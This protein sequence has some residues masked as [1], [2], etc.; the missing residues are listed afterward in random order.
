MKIRYG[1]VTNSSSSSFIVAFNNESEI[2]VPLEFHQRIME[3]ILNPQNS[4]TVEQALDYFEECCYYSI[5]YDV[6]DKMREDLG[7]GYDRYE[8]WLKWKKEHSEEI[9]QKAQE[10]MNRQKEK[11]RKDIEG[12]KIIS[13]INYSDDSSDEESKLENFCYEM[14][15]CYAVLSF[16]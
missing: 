10:E 1:F 12:K 11:L 5:H 15:G 13:M 3:D 14:D 6:T 8:E 7:F 16:H 2:H 9:E 4:I